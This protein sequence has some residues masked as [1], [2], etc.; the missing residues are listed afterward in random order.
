MGSLGPWHI[1]IAV[2]LSLVKFP[3]AWQQLSIV[4]LA[5]PTNFSCIAPLSATNESMFMRCKVD[6]GNGT[7]EKCTE[8]IYDKKVFRESI[9][10]KVRLMHCTIYSGN[11]LCLKCNNI[12]TRYTDIY[13]GT[14]CVI[15]SNWGILYSPS[16]CSVCSLAT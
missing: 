4:F 3:V 10:T 2:A 8:F 5:P 9:I 13:S 12:L 16:Q 7:I 1:V 11:K 14:W 6:V 15:K